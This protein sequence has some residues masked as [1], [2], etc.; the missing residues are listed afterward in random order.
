M[1]P[2]ALATC[3]RVQGGAAKRT[4]TSVI[5]RYIDEAVQQVANV[6]M[7]ENMHQTRIFRLLLVA[8]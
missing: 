8:I 4:K 3:C 1:C 7:T 6:R 2:R 5:G